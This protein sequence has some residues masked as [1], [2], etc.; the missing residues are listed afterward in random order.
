MP[1]QCVKCNALYADDA[2][3]MM[4]GCV[5]GSKAF[6]FKKERPEETPGASKENVILEVESINTAEDGKYELDLHALFGKSNLVIRHEEGKYSVDLQ[7]SFRRQK[8]K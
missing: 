6:V 5:C 7:E 1:H 4:Q 2:P 8:L 3:E